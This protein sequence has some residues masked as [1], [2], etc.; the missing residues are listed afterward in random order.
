MPDSTGDSKCLGQ[1]KLCLASTTLSLRPDAH[2][3]PIKLAHCYK[4]Q[5]SQSWHAAE[6]LQPAKPHVIMHAYL[7]HQRDLSNTYSITP[8]VKHRS[9]FMT[10]SKFANI[11]T[12]KHTLNKR[13]QCVLVMWQLSNGVAMQCQFL[14]ARKLAKLLHITQ[15]SDLIGVQIQHLQP[16]KARQ[17][18]L[19]VCQL[20]L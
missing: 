10:Y 17:L 6:N 3:I 12:T 8:M 1:C 15:S 20:A 2:C 19:D 14:Q 18:I 5:L 11:A 9:F 7:L 4:V 13:R 16:G